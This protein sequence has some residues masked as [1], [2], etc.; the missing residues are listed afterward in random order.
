MAMDRRHREV[1][2]VARSVL[3]QLDVEVVL[4]RILRAARE[5]TGARF[6]ALGVLD[7]SRTGLDRFLTLGLDDA[8]RRRIGSP[9]TGRGVLGELIRVQQPLRVGDIGRHP[10]S[11]GF[12]SGHPPMRSFLGVPITVGDEPWGNLYLTEKLDGGVFD[13]D[14]ERWVVLLAGFA[15]LAVDHARRFSA[16]EDQRLG[17]QQTVTALDATMQISRALG[18]ETE[19]SA[20]LELV[21]TRGRALV[22]ARA[23]VIELLDGD[24]L[25]LAAGA[26]QLPDDLLGRRVALA[27]TVASAALSTGRSRRLS[28]PDSRTR[29]EQHGLGTLGLDAQ[30]G[31]VVPL[32]F[33]GR[34][35]GVL[36]AVDRED[37]DAFTLEHQQL[38]ESFAAS[39]AT[40]VATAQSV[41]DER[42]RQR[43]AAAEDERSRWARE[44]HDETLQALGGL[45]LL[46]AGSL[47]GDEAVKDAA[48][49][50]AVAQL[51]SD[52][53]SLRALITELRPAALDQLGLEPALLALIDRVRLGGLDVDV[54]IDLDGAPGRMPQRL[55]G[56]LE[57]GIYRIVQEALTNAVKHGGAERAVVEV[58][59]VGGQVT[60]AVRDDGAGFDPT[61]AT[62][63]FGLVGMRER[64]ELLDGTIDTDSVPGRGT[65]IQVTLPVSRR[66]QPRPVP[67]GGTDVANPA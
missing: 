13:E 9:P 48:I 3:E 33:R 42:L 2:T 21:A 62:T 65:T 24:R 38:L 63:G 52:I 46:L 47:R 10:A 49:G 17:L 44:L 19:L 25:E 15:G 64:A 67:N 27:G 56:E 60:V 26:G 23:L 37:G 54:Q 35:Y 45:R 5:L 36:V 53:A 28:D 7:E 50:Q 55:A 18:G 6:A 30:D 22:G 40:A 16:S 11:Y 59:E 32:V 29:F 20:I 41:A 4:Q 1:L 43:Q 39:A 12:P 66:P 58:T 57:T 51:E 31:L 14:D 61:T 8:A 34:G